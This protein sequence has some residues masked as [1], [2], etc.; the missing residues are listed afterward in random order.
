MV[1]LP[2]NEAKDLLKDITGLGAAEVAPF[3][4][5]SHKNMFAIMDEDRSCVETHTKAT[6]EYLKS[7]GMAMTQEELHQFKIP[8]SPIKRKNVFHRLEQGII[9]RH[10]PLG[11]LRC[12]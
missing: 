10:F 12:Q 8:E 5:S 11:L 4:Y 1:R 3:P 7:L 2:D 9:K 6:D